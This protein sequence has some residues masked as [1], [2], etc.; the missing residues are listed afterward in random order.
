VNKRDIRPVLM[1]YLIFNFFSYTAILLKVLEMRIRGI[2]TRVIL[3][4]LFVSQK[5]LLA[6]IM[7]SLFFYCS[8]CFGEMH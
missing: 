6:S 3:V 8:F 2:D 4:P 7:V 5:S 1:V